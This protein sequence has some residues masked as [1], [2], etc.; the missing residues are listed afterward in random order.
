MVIVD[1]LGVVD[2]ATNSNDL[3]HVD[4]IKLP[5]SNR[6]FEWYV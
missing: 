2:V 1:E 3:V 4:A 6:R 5:I